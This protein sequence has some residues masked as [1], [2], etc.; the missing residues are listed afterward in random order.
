MD[1]TARKV[2]QNVAELEL[3]LANHIVNYFIRFWKW[4]VREIF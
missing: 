4:T 2:N 3:N 1:F